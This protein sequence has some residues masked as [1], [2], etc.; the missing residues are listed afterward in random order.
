MWIGFTEGWLSIVEHKDRPEMLLVRAREESHITNLW[1]DAEIIVIPWADYRF[2]AEIS[3]DD[4]ADVIAS[5][6][7]NIQY[8]DFKSSVKE[9]KLN[10]A[11][12][13]IWSII[14][15]AFQSH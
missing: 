7:L 10:K 2:R 6:L 9:R 8:H 5:Q 13:K 15:G 14:R 3:R 12:H 4:V 1:M 11:Y